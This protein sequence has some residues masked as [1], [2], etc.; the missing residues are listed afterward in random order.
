MYTC[1]WE[2][3]LS[4]SYPKS[5]PS[6]DRKRADSDLIK[7][8]LLF[9]A[10]SRLIIVTR[11]S[12][13]M[14]KYEKNMKKW[15]CNVNSNVPRLPRDAIWII[16]LFKCHLFGESSAS[17]HIYFITKVYRVFVPL[18]YASSIMIHCL[19][20]KHVS[21]VNPLFVTCFYDQRNSL[22]TFRINEEK[23]FLKCGMYR[24]KR[25]I[26]KWR[27]T[28]SSLYNLFQIITTTIVILNQY[29]NI[30]IIGAI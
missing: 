30:L 1:L 3:L 2:Y 20:V 8:K 6:L 15:T 24:R 21:H 26:G 4:H 9:C 12:T 29:F 19:P 13:N 25:T 28:N 5:L 17:C 27:T 14:Q 23:Y 10:F 16:A 7:F 11:T 18:K 22:A